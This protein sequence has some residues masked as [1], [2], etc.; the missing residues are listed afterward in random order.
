MSNLVSNKIHITTIIYLVTYTVYTDGKLYH[1][2]QDPSQY[3]VVKILKNI[4]LTS[5]YTECSKTMLCEKI[6]YTSIN[7]SY[8]IDCYLEQS[9]LHEIID[10][11]TPDLKFLKLV[12]TYLKFKKEVYL[13]LC[14][15]SMIE[16]FRS[17]RPAC[18]FNK[19]ETLAQ[20]FSCE[21][22][23]ICKNTFFTEHFRWQVLDI[24]LAW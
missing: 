11:K 20:V 10:R 4:L 13:N 18:N 21:F 5:C 17:S 6:E 1:I 22:C 15:T 7:H 14:R 9:K 8:L 16:I 2:V 23:E 19:K 3:K 24:L 12:C